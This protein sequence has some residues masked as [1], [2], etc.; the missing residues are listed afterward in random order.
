MTLKQLKTGQWFRF[1]SERER[2]IVVSGLRTCNDLYCNDCIECVSL[3]TGISW[4]YPEEC[5][6]V[7]VHK[8]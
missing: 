2:W 7:R 4:Y 6:I 1:K 8:T 5:I 3:M